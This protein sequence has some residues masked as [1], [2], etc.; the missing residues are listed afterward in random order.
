[1][2]KTFDSEK[3]DGA[4]N[5]IALGKWVT[6]L[7]HWHLQSIVSDQGPALHSLPTL[8]FISYVLESHDGL[9]TSGFLPSNPW[10]R[11]PPQFSFQYTNWNMWLPLIRKF[12]WLCTDY[13]MKPKPWS[14]ACQILHTLTLTYSSSWISCHS[15]PC[16]PQ[17]IPLSG[18]ILSYPKSCS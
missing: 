4:L 18:Y 6:G 8:L 15:P 1:M 9:P 5:S 14:L 10:S 16:T 11:W 13:R 7:H 3:E 12:L 2:Y 17:L